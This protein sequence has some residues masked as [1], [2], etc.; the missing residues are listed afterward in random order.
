VW[1]TYQISLFNSKAHT[2]DHVPSNRLD[3]L[4]PQKTIFLPNTVS[5]RKVYY[6][7]PKPHVDARIII[8]GEHPTL[9]YPNA[10]GKSVDNFLGTVDCN[11]PCAT[12]NVFGLQG[13]LAQPMGCYLKESDIGNWVV[14][15]KRSEIPDGFALGKLVNKMEYFNPE[16]DCD[17]EPYIS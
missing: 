7:P 16:D 12:N 6:F 3:V 8:S 14:S 5:H 9:K 2:K 1:T 17:L 4:I 15:T 13:R 11:L 10:P